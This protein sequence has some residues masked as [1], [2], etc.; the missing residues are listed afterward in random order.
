M[1]VT[2]NISVMNFNIQFCNYPMLSTNIRISFMELI[3]IWEGS[4]P[5]KKN[6]TQFVKFRFIKHV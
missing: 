4:F 5:K 6:K 3:K 2:I 1:L